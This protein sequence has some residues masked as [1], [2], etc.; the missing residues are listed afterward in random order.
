MLT[1]PNGEKCPAVHVARI[2]TGETEETYINA[3]SRAGG[4][5]GGKARAE[6]M[7]TERR[8]DIAKATAARWS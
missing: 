7:S 2:A 6:S 8:S 1:G 5:K 3:G 4:R